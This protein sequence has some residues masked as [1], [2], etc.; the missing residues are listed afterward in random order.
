MKDGPAPKDMIVHAFLSMG[1]RPMDPKRSKFGK[2]FGYSLLFWERDKKVLSQ[3]VRAEND[4]HIITYSSIEIDEG[5]SV[6][7]I[8]DAIRSW[9]CFETHSS[10]TGMR[11]TSKP[12]HGFH[13][14]STE[15]V[16]SGFM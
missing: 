16:F 9:E 4:G 2:P 14:L 15:E 13:F 3:V 10:G 5:K 11:W 6:Q 1:Y 12:E 8:F 7:E